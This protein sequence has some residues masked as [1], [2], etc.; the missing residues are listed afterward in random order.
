MHPPLPAG[1]WHAYEVRRRPKRMRKTPPTTSKTRLYTRRK[2]PRNPAEPPSA[3]KT[4]EN[5]PT[6]SRAC[7]RISGEN[8][9]SETVSSSRE[10]PVMKVT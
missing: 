2:L 9:R 7:R 6:K 5:P 8:P 1:P 4:R 10:A 3:M